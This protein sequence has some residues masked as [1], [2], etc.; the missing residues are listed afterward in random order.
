[1]SFH[2]RLG[3]G[4]PSLE[5]TRKRPAPWTWNG[6]CIGWSDSISLTSRIFTL[7]PTLNAQEIRWFSAPVSRSMSFQSMLVGSEARLISGIRSSH[8]RPSP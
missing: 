8:S 1:M 4:L 5:R 7:S 2:T 6:W 3:S